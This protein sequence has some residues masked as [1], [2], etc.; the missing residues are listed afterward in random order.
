MWPLW[1]PDQPSVSSLTDTIR[2]TYFIAWLLWSRNVDR[3][4]LDF[5]C[6]SVIAQLPIFEY[7]NHR[8][9]HVLLFSFYLCLVLY[10]SCIRFSYFYFTVFTVLLMYTYLVYVLFHYLHCLW[11]CT[12]VLLYMFLFFLFDSSATSINESIPF[13]RCGECN[14]F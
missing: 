1:C 3:R 7:Q 8:P 10:T 2:R 4:V 6:V 11:W 13:D 9:V 12:H 5:D 14:G